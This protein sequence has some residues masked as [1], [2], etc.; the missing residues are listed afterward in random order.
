MN[1]TIEILRKRVAEGLPLNETISAMH[2]DGLSII[3]AIKA[4]RELFGINLGDAKLV[5]TSHPSYT[6]VADAAKPSTMN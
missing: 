6:Q 5:V 3:D 2:P 4:T 1:N